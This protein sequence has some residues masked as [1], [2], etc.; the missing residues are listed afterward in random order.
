MPQLIQLESIESK[1][2][3][4]DVST[5]DGII[6]AFYEVISGPA[7]MP[8]QWERD[9]TLYAPGAISASSRLD[10]EG[11]RFTL[12][13]DVDGFIKFAEPRLLGGFFEYETSR[14][15]FKVG[16][17]THVFSHYESRQTADGPVIGRGIN[18]IELIYA[19]GRYWIV[20]ALW[21][22]ATEERE[23]VQVS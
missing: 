2:N 16:N 22:S 12:A 21:D 3:S 19:A 7:G 5:I 18:S 1:A 14:T 9:R 15:A 4:E 10:A 17:V 11:K 13:M 8:R 6:R 23:P 20:A